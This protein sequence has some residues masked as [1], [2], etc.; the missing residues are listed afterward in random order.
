[1][2]KRGSR[3]RSSTSSGGAK[4]RGA[5]AQAGLAAGVACAA[6]SLWLL[7]SALTK[8]PFD[9]G[10]LGEELLIAACAVCA[11]RLLCVAKPS[12]AAAITLWVLLFGLVAGYGLLAADGAAGMG[13]LCVAAALACACWCAWSAAGRADGVVLCVILLAAALPVLTRQAALSDRLLLALLAAGAAASAG[14]IRRQSVSL[15]LLSAA[16]FTLAG[17]TTFYAGFCAVGAAAGLLLAGARS[18]RG[19]WALA[20]LFL[21]ALPFAARFLAARY[22]VLPDVLNA[23]GGQA[24]AGWVAP[25]GTHVLRTLAAGLLLFAPRLLRGQD[26]AAILV[27]C[28][29]AAGALARLFFGADMPGVWTDAPSIA[30]LA[31]VGIATIAAKGAR[32]A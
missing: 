25:Y 30:A 5:Y 9:W 10:T 22:I 7:F 4:P 24:A 2:A 27:A 19:D 15:A 11:L 23:V 13:V 18:R 17:A 16:A 29:L 32:S 8:K 21:A 14:A 6:L 31:G 12:R 28:M 3:K 1:M 26:R 20:A